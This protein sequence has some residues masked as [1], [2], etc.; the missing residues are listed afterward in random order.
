MNLFFDM[1]HE[2]FVLLHMIFLFYGAWYYLINLFLW[3]MNEWHD[4]VWVRSLFYQWSMIFF[5]KL[6]ITHDIFWEIFW[7]G[8]WYFL[9]NLFCNAW[10][11]WEICFM[12]HDVILWV[13]NLFMHDIFWARNCVMVV[14]WCTIIFE[15]C[16]MAHDIFWEF[17]LWHMI[18]FDKFVLWRMIFLRNLFLQCMIFFE[19]FVLL[20]MIFFEKFVLQYVIFWEICFAIRD[21][22]RNLFCNAWYFWEICFMAHDVLWVRN[23]F[24]CIWYCFTIDIFINLF[25]AWYIFFEWEI[26]LWCMK[27]WMKF[28]MYDILSKNFLR[29]FRC[30]NFWINSITYYFLSENFLRYFD[31]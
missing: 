5:E 3:R 15:I 30:I 11:F 24:Y 18:F 17:V 31:V 4:I 14:L 20:R 28:V 12:V 22:L 25:Y 19:K 10:Y 16:F 1:V 2:K 27:F 9:R 23:L 29:Y 21:I 8:T 7:Y 26:V 13:R 6:F